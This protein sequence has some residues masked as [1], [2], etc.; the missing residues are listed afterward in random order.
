M[1]CSVPLCSVLGKQFN[2]S[3]SVLSHPFRHPSFV[4]R[5][6]KSI[7]LQDLFPLPQFG[8]FLPKPQ[9]VL[10]HAWRE[11]EPAN[12][13]YAMQQTDSL[14]RNKHSVF[15]NRFVS[16]LILGFLTPPPVLL[17]LHMQFKLFNINKLIFI[18]CYLRVR[19]QGF[20]KK[21]VLRLFWLS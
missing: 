13:G 16:V 20:S 7:L 12:S 4:S 8:L 5:G 6:L 15:W 11:L 14:N 3:C 18:F 19:L 17:C 10:Y 9:R 2:P 1:F 21:S